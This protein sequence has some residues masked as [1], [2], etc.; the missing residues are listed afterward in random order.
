VVCV[1]KVFPC[2]GEL[3][4]AHPCLGGGGLKTGFTNPCRNAIGRQNEPGYGRVFAPGQR[5]GITG[6][7]WK[8]N[9]PKRGG[10]IEGE[11]NTDPNRS[12]GGC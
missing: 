11:S 9:A 2:P 6:V 8:C 12:A 1:P 10:T 7:S 5:A 4:G 3:E